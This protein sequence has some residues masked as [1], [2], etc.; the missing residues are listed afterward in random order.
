M[1]TIQNFYD[2]IAP[3][4][5]LIHGDWNSSLERQATA[6]DGIIKEFWGTGVKTILDLACGIG[7]QTIGLAQLGYHVT[8]SD[9]SAAAIERPRRD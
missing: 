9:L 7:T 2:E 8:A 3:F 4:Y 5:H 6:L 1:N